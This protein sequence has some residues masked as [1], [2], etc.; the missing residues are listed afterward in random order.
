VVL[1]AGPEGAIGKVAL[2]VLKHSPVPVM[3]VRE[4]VPADN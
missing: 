4:P 1:G 2:A 3:I